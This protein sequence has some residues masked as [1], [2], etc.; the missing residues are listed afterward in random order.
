MESGD[1]LKL[2]IFT[3]P[4]YS[5]REVTCGNRYNSKSLQ[6]IR[7]AYDFFALQKCDLVVCLGD[8]TDQDD[9]HEKEVCNL[10]EIS[11]VINGCA[12]KTVCLMGN[13]D[14][15]TFSE[16]EFYEILH[17]EKPTCVEVEN[18][19]FLFLDACYFKNGNHYLPGDRDWTDTFFPYT[20]ELKQRLEDAAGDVYIFIHQNTD[21]NIREDHR[22]HNSAEINS[23]LQKSKKVKAVFQG[24][25]HSGMKSEYANIAYL[26]FPAMCENEDAYYV[27]HI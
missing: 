27:L 14:A 25:Y 20:K 26:T 11:N 24:H 16:S 9:S 6:K 7:D 4:H 10:K 22:L 5:S 19:T 21:P 3:D 2:G 23:I 18:K 13:H 8:L 12:I 17:L 15:F 1:I